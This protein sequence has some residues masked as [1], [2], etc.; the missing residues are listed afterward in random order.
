MKG[1]LYKVSFFSSHLPITDSVLANKEGFVQ[2]GDGTK[3]V[4]LIYT[5]TYRRDEHRTSYGREELNE[6]PSLA[7]FLSDVTTV[8]HVDDVG[9]HDN[10][11]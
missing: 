2:L 5:K 1:F 11:W 9:T 3:H 10:G 8:I 6:L 4:F 7:K